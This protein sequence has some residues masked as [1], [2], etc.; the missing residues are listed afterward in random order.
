MPIERRPD[1]T[2]VIYPARMQF[3]DNARSVVGEIYV[4][5]DGV[6]HIGDVSS[7]GGGG[8]GPTSQ[9]GLNDL[10]IHTGTLD[11]NQAPQFLKHNGSRAMTGDLA[12]G[13]NAITSVGLVDGV[14][15]SAHAARH[16]SG[17]ADVVDHDSLTGFV[18]DEHIAHSGVTLTAGDGLTGGGTIAA[19]RT[20]ALTTPGT[21]S[22]SS[23]NASAGNHAHAITTSSNPGANA[24]ILA[25]NASGYLELEGLGI[26]ASATAQE[27]RL[28]GNLVFVGA[29][30]ITTTIDGLTLAPADGLSFNP[31]AGDILFY[32]DAA[33]EDWVSGLLGTGWGISHA[34]AGDFRSIYS[35]EIRTH[36]FIAEIYSA[37]AGAIILTQSRAKV[38][39]NF[40]IPNTGAAAYLYVEDLEGFGGSQVFAANDYVLLRVMTH[41]TDGEGLVVANVYGQ[42]TAYQ[43]EAEG[44]QR[45]T[46][47]TTTQAYAAADVIYQG[48]VVLDYGQL[49]SGSQGVWQA[50]VLGANAP[51]SGVQT[52]DTVTNGEPS[53]FTTWTRLG[54]LQGI[55]TVG[56]EYGLW[57]GQG[58]GDGDA[59]V[60]VSD[61][62]VEL[63]NLPFKVHDGAN[64]VYLVDPTV[65]SYALG[66]SVPTGFA[67]GVGVWA[68]LD[69]GAYKWRVGDPS[70]DKI[71]WDGT[72][73]SVV[74]SVTITD[75]SVDFADVF[76]ATKPADNATVGATW[77]TNL[78]S[79]P[80]TLGTPAGAGLF[81][82]ATYMGYYAGGA[83]TTYI[84]NNGDFL[85]G[86]PAGA[87]GLSWDQSASTLSIKGSITLTNT[88]DYADISGA[89]KPA[90]NAD[91][92]ADNAQ[93]VAWLTDGGA[94]ATEDNLDGVPNGATYARVLKTGIAAGK[95]LLTQ[96]DGDLDDIA[97]GTYAKVL[98]T[99]LSAGHIKLTSAT[100]VA[101]EWYD[102]S[103]V[104]LDATTGINIYGT[105]NA[106]TTRATKT[107]TIQCAVNS[108]GQIT[109]GAGNVVL[110]A[111]GISIATSTQSP[112]LDINL[113]KF[114]D[115]SDD[116]SLYITSIENLGVNSN[117]IVAANVAGYS[118]EMS[119]NAKA[120]T[121]KYASVRLS[122]DS[123]DSDAATV[124]AWSMETTNSAYVTIEPDLRVSGG[125]YVGS[126]GTDPDADDIYYDGNL[127]SHKNST[128]YDVY[129]FHPLTTALTSTSWDGDAK[130]TGNNGTI[131]LSSVFGAP[132]GIKAVLVRFLIKGAV[133]ITGWLG[134]SSGNSVVVART[135]IADKAWNAES[136]CPCDAN[137]DIWFNTTGNLT[138]VHIIIWGYWI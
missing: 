106:L 28:D 121:G 63:H 27:I 37:M 128:N 64:T 12:M 114:I 47:T 90:N 105:N 109:A 52:W 54:Y 11:D 132:A 23:I 62:N 55:A 25:S 136:I 94:L 126:T 65:P 26:G 118:S 78:D 48:S 96:V 46:F 19:S 127:K 53:N 110:D 100:V 44:E 93:N 16:E 74:G 30:S 80:A 21:L 1:R 38:S 2:T 81:L 125:L 67:S 97:N 7:G 77:G 117:G 116:I 40:T 15:V 119:L 31:A 36:A 18:S 107:G 14:T 56:D 10:A 9:H 42:V 50:T 131:D 5:A 59:W 35:E 72:N 57:A 22:I 101:G 71:E 108:D 104:E 134:P 133:D 39:R 122:A 73:L 84:A 49:G 75:K 91:V 95:I 98:A 79:I 51:Y 41:G 70:G 124:T 3:M 68:G 43:D 83:W 34:G 61:Q 113:I 45:W 13:G 103:G 4:D 137:G 123:V 85:L 17:G 120:P 6:L 60:L 99:D 87:S 138:E 102:S 33:T 76:G 32:D 111:D 66:S 92:T 89:T 112:A 135:N 8:T 129:G 29:Q 88:I 24:Q 130:T 115:G 69:A 58:T 20:F 82:A 86:N